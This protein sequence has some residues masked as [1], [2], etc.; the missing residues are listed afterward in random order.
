MAPLP[1][2][3]RVGASAVPHSCRTAPAAGPA[4]ARQPLPS[5]AGR[6]A[7]FSAGA[8]LLSSRRRLR[9]AHAQQRS[10][11][12]ELPSGAALQEAPS[13][14]SYAGESSE[15]WK[16][17]MVSPQ[18]EAGKGSFNWLKQ[19]YPVAVIDQ[20]CTDK[21]KP[22]NLQLLGK[23]LV[24]WFDQV[25]SKWRCFEDKCPH[26]LAPLSEGR[27]EADGTL[28]CAYHAWRF[29]GSGACTSL[30]QAAKGVEEK[31]RTNKRACAVNFPTMEAQG[32]LW[33]W[34][35]PSTPDEAMFSP[36]R[37]IPEL[38]P[39]SLAAGKAV[40]P[41]T[42]NQR[43]L[44][45]GWEAFFENVTDGS[46]VPVS[47]HGI[48]GNRYTDANPIEYRTVTPLTD[49]DGFRTQPVQNALNGDVSEAS[50][51]DFKPPCLMR[52]E[53]VQKGGG[54]LI[55]VLYAVPT[56]PGWCRHIGT[57]VLVKGTDGTLPRGFAQFS[58]PMP[59]W[60]LHSLASLFLHQDMV[61]L[62]HQQKIL[63]REQEVLGARW[64]DVCYMPA[65]AD[66]STIMFRQWLQRNGSEGIVPWAAGTDRRI[67]P[68]QRD[69]VK[70]FDVYHTH[71]KNC[72]HCSRAAT[73]FANARNALGVAA[74]ASGA[75]A[76]GVAGALA[77]VAGAGSSVAP[78]VSLPVALVLTALLAAASFAIHQYQ[79]LFYVYEYAHQ[80]NN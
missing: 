65:S 78:P 44:P 17:T 47:H 54:M 1:A 72:T 23:D 10:A 74:G 34:A 33:V 41:N 15:E 50:F 21:S 9:A 76:L 79:K 73:R 77:T 19:W 60:L 14:S 40:M 63:E 58:T 38:S 45:Y 48:T 5:L 13:T 26:R 55:L 16:T 75:Y 18:A 70:L 12:A 30:P 24:I 39:E 2:S 4:A 29:D 6:S 11:V 61:F 51:T 67:P 31:A 66:K 28:L 56:K 42:W 32:L 49:K 8:A 27:V 25:Q 64:L 43:D 37:L 52:I 22:H 20:D 62:H 68:I 71:T 53:N 57:T 80:D 7:Q 36:P 69:G 3:L 46:H 59:V 35:D